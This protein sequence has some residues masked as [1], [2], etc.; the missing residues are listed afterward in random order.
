LTDPELPVAFVRFAR[1]YVGLPTEPSGFCGAVTLDQTAL[2]HGISYAPA[3]IR[4]PA[5]QCSSLV[6]AGRSGRAR[7]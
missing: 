4:R 3:G 1:S 7:L 6:R 5:P 2:T